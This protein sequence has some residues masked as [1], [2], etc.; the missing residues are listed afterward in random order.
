MG[1]TC[2]D[3]DSQVSTMSP[4][5]TEATRRLRQ[6]LAED[7]TPPHATPI[8]P[9]RQGDALLFGRAPSCLIG[10]VLADPRIADRLRSHVVDEAQVCT[11]QRCSCSRLPRWTRWT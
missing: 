6:L 10:D 1:P 3:R 7:H 8:S 2:P 5:W 11:G 9:T 4:R